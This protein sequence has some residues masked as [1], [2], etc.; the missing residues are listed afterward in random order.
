MNGLVYTPSVAIQQG[1][2]LGEV[3]NLMTLAPAGWLVSGYL[4][5]RLSRLGTQIRRCVELKFG[6]RIAFSTST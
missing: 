4:V 6:M 1:R 5:Y 3:K 2:P